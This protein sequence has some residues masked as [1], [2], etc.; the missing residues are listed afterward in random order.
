MISDCAEGHGRES[1]YVDT[2]VRRLGQFTGPGDRVDGLAN[3]E[4]AGVDRD[5]HGG[6]ERMMVVR[7]KE[8]NPQRPASYTRRDSSPRET[9][10]KP[11]Q[12]L[13]AACPLSEPVITRELP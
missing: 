4:G 3:D 12:L 1:A 5:L 10:P 11:S 9:S 7:K 13:L 6:E 2:D 8:R